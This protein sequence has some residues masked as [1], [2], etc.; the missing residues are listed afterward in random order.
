MPHSSALRDV[1]VQEI[2]EAAT[3]SMLT[4]LLRSE[5]A[6]QD[7][8]EAYQY[9]G[10]LAGGAA[11]SNTF[12]QLIFNTT[13]PTQQQVDIAGDYIAAATALHSIYTGADLAA[14]R[15]VS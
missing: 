15:R 11:S 3:R 8:L 2:L 10:I 5:E 9:S 14:L 12:S 4:A 13:T 6:Y 7:L 1:D